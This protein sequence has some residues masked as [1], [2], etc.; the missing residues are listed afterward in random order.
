MLF[1][2]SSSIMLFFVPKSNISGLKRLFLIVFRPLSSDGTTVVFHHALND[3]IPY[4]QTVFSRIRYVES[5]G[6][7][8]TVAI[9][10]MKYESFTIVTLC[11]ATVYNSSTF[12]VLFLLDGYFTFLRDF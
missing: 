2:R 8:N 9:K 7:R 1:S 10:M 4:S 3:Q 11:L 12:T 6:G 5:R